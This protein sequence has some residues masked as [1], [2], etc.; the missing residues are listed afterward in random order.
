MNNPKSSKLSKV[1][2]CTGCISANTR[3]HQLYLG[4]WELATTVSSTK[5][6]QV[7]YPQS[8]SKIPHHVNHISSYLWLYCGLWQLPMRF[9]SYLYHENHMYMSCVI[10]QLEI[11]ASLDNVEQLQPFLMNTRGEPFFM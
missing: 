6:S 5:L 10:W 1:T 2:H 11:R 9:G 7:L 4:D 8:S 3:P